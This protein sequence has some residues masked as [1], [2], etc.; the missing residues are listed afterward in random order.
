MTDPSAGK[1]DRPLTEMT[2]EELMAIKADWEARGYRIHDRSSTE[3]VALAFIAGNFCS[4]FV[5][6]LGQRAGNSVANLPKRTGD[7]VRK[8]VK[9]RGRP[10]ECHISAGTDAAATVAITA[11]TPDEARLALLDLDVAAEKL[12]GKVLRWDE[13]AHAWRPGS[14]CNEAGEPTADD[15]DE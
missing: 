5:Q 3:Q 14:A 2:A 6:A 4:A 15:Q 7:L 10:G 13:E 8:F 11:D 12:R 1:L 9:Q